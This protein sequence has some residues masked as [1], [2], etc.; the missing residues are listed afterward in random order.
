MI[1]ISSSMYMKY[2]YSVGTCYYSVLHYKSFKVTKMSLF[3][4]LIS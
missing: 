4:K 3:G 1:G 2:N